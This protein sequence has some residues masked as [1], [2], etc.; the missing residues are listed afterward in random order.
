LKLSHHGAN[1]YVLLL[2]LLPSFGEYKAT[3]VASLEAAEDDFSAT[4]DTR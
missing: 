1:I 2:Q 4:D 3:V